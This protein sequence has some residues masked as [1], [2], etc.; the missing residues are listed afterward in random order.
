MNEV[1]F[2]ANFIEQEGEY[3]EIKGEHQIYLVGKC[4]LRADMP[5][6]ES[7]KSNFTVWGEH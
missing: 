2:G 6:D 3:I 5:I 4:I 7:I 1:F